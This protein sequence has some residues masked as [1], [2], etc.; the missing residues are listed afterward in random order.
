MASR[1]HLLFF[2]I[3][4]HRHAGKK[5][6]IKMEQKH[7]F[8]HYAD[9]RDEWAAM[10]LSPWQANQQSIGQTQAIQRK[11]DEFQEWAEMDIS[12]ENRCPETGIL[13]SEFP[14]E[15]E[16]EELLRRY[17]ANK[18]YMSRLAVIAE[19]RCKTPKEWRAAEAEE[20][21]KRPPC[22]IG[23]M[24]HKSAFEMQEH[25]GAKAFRKRTAEIRLLADISDC[26]SEIAEYDEQ[27]IKF[28]QTNRK[29]RL[30]SAINKMNHRRERIVHLKI[31]LAQ[32]QR[33]ISPIEDKNMQWLGI[34]EKIKI[35]DT[36]RIIAEER[37]GIGTTY[38]FNPLAQS[39]E[40]AEI[41]FTD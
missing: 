16:D 18:D 33:K 3:N 5:R 23:V 34:T 31:K 14:R 32:L 25:Y 36:A 12:S 37:R 4:P 19:T 15:T 6:A 26:E 39:R 9:V 27:R 13:E 24:T 28:A 2:H 20:K 38:G 40:T 1:A 29:N 21:I 8:Q 35:A 41:M 22:G 7:L 11:S 30:R 10:N 17:N